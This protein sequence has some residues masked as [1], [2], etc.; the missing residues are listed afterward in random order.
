VSALSCVACHKQ[1]MI[2]PPPDE[3]R[4]FARV[5]DK[6]RDHVRRL[7]PTA[8]EFAAQVEKDGQLFMSVLEK[9][10][11]PL[12]RTG[13]DANRNL[14]DFPEPVFEVGREYLQGELDLHAIAAELHEPNIERVR[15]KIEGDDLLQRL[16]LGVLLRPDG[17]IKRAFWE[18]AQGGP[19]VM[20][21]AAFAL[22][23][24]T[25]QFKE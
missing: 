14:S 6:S 2:T 1:G 15:S 21:L 8:T 5:F 16:G 3:I 13:D 9:T 4:D 17:K 22:D 18:S 11:G 24:T 7:Y 25:L 12:L 10:I 19:S 23:Y 20:Q